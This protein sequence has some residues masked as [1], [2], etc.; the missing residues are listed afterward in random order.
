MTDS[1][2]PSVSNVQTYSHAASQSQVQ[3]QT[4]D[5]RNEKTEKVILLVIYCYLQLIVSQVTQLWRL[6]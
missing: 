4:Q 5:D 3:T 1:P 6:D 2:I